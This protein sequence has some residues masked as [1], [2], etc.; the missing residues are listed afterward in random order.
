VEDVRLGSCCNRRKGKLQ[1]ETF[2]S[3]LPVIAGH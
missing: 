2:F 3:E 1:K